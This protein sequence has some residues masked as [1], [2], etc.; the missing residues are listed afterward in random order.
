MSTLTFPQLATGALAQFPIRKH[1]LQRTIVNRSIGEQLIKMTDP[2][3]SKVCWDL[4]YTGLTDLEMNA[5]EALFEACEGRLRPFR[6][7]DPLGNLLRWTE[8]LSKTVWQT[9]LIVATGIQ[10]VSGSTG[11]CRLTN[12]AQGP[13]SISQAVNSP[14]AYLYTLSLWVK[15]I[16][17][18]ALRLGLGRA[19]NMAWV[20]RHVTADWQQVSISA[21]VPGDEEPVRCSIEIPGGTAIDVYGPQLDAQNDASGYRRSTDKPGV[22]VARFD[23]DEIERISNGS[24]DHSTRLRVVTVQE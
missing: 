16:S 13:Q 14:A 7:V 10:D 6:F 20:D 1:V 21:W 24:D 12:G 8:D 18:G 3:G 17:S 9:G 22:Y 23:Q 5:L 11:A 19:G 4:L 2:E 15:S